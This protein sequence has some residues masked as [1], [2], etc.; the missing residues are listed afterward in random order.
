MLVS[1]VVQSVEDNS[2]VPFN[3]DAS[4]QITSQGQVEANV[5]E[6]S[7]RHGGYTVVLIS[8]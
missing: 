2:T 4:E 7:R 8:P 5:T 6:T 3:E 1:S